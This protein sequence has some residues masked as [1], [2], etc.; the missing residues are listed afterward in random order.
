[1]SDPFEPLTADQMV[2]EYMRR[3]AATAEH[4]RQNI[5]PDPEDHSP[6]GVNQDGPYSSMA[7]YDSAMEQFAN[8]TERPVDLGALA[9]TH[10]NTGQ[11]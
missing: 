6:F 8:F 1:M 11:K 5:L 10:S 3:S 4:E 2:A 7:D 9:G